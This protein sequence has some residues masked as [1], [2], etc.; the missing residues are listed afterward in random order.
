[1]RMP[2]TLGGLAVVLTLCLGLTA[3]GDNLDEGGSGTAG[4]GDKGSLTIASAGFTESQVMAEMYAAVLR[5]AGYTIEIKTV[6]NREL[7]EPALEKGEVDVVPDYAATMAEFLNRKK[8]GPDAPP[9]ASNDVDKTVAALRQLAEPLGLL[10]LEP[11]KAVDQNA[12]VVSKEFAE[13]NNLKTLSDLG[14]SGK[15]VSLAAGEECADRPFCKPGLEK[16][17]GIKITKID[18]LGVSTAQT[19]KSVQDGKNQ[20]GLALT[21]DGSLESFGLVVLEDDKGLQN[22]DNLIPVVNKESAGSDDV[23]QALNQLSETLTT[24]DLAS[25]NQKVDAERQ[26]ADKVAQDYLKEKGLL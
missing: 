6:D 16:T 18:P 26:K 7:Y 5:N 25:L 2:R 20:L 11:S 19:K 1:M 12:F 14:R 15:A 8:N 13:Q 22:A 21:T 3:C 24:E 4:G 23:A 10:V 9:V 17:Y